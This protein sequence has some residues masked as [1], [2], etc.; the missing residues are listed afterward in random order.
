MLNLSN[1]GILE[2][3]KRKEKGWKKVEKTRNKQIIKT[4]MRYQ[5]YSAAGNSPIWMDSPVSIF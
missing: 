1:L 3:N 4:V 5:K 2:K